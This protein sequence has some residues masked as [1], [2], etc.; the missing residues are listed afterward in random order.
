[1]GILRERMAQDL[2]LRNYSP[3]TIK[4]YLFTVQQF[5]VHFRRSPRQLGEVELR[6]YLDYLLTEKQLA[7]SSVNIAYHALRFCYETTLQ[8]EWNIGRL[9]RPR[10][11][12][13]LPVVLSPQEVEMTLAQVRSPKQ[14]AILTVMYSAGLR[15]GEAVQLCVEDI[16]SQR[17]T[18]R[19]RQGKGRRDRYTILAQ[20]TL[21]LLRE[22]W[23]RYR[24]RTWLFPGISQVKPLSTRSVQ[25]AFQKGLR[26]AGIIKPASV[27]TL[28]HSFATHLLEQGTNLA[29]ISRLLGHSRLQTTGIYLHISQQELGRV[30][31]PW[32]RS[33]PLP[34]SPAR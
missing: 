15:V 8:Q 17:M 33:H 22:Y 19:V 31:S 20:R 26:A 13:Q 11:A 24:P 25:R 23:R 3:K 29:H 7:F 12:K 6:Q 28:R 10:Q 4:A 30:I 18:I 21:L 34:S 5:A 1:M 14:R 2:R 27:H 16:D 9:P 32:D